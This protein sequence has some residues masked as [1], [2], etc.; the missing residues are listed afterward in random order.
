MTRCVGRIGPRV[1]LAIA[2]AAA[3]LLA[4]ARASAQV[5][6]CRQHACPPNRRC[7][8]TAYA[9]F[10]DDYRCALDVAAGA[11]DFALGEGAVAVAR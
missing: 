3:E 11:S 7:T 4:L 2:L 1:R 5:Q 8:S 9:S 6:R 10:D